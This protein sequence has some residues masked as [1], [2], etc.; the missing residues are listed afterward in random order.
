MIGC[1]KCHNPLYLFDLNEYG[2]CTECGHDDEE[3]E[4][5]E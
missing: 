5:E 2:C 1:P 3:P 4:K